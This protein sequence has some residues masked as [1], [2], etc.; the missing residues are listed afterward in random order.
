MGLQDSCQLQ[1]SVTSQQQGLGCRMQRGHLL[2]MLLLL[3]A[4]WHTAVC[5][6]MLPPH[7]PGATLVSVLVLVLQL[8]PAHPIRQVMAQPTRQVSGRG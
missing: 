8:H 5:P 4:G 7:L 6:S 3:Q 2:R 1:V